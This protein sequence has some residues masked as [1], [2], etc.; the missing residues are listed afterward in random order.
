MHICYFLN[1][2]NHTKTVRSVKLAQPN[3]LQSGIKPAAKNKLHSIHH[4]L[5]L[6]S[7][8]HHSSFKILTS[9]EEKSASRQFCDQ[10][11]GL[12]RKFAYTSVTAVIISGICQQIRRF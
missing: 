6:T 10:M 2:E 5:L 1:T 12:Q 11:D 3:F 7:F 4:L 9:Y 8:V